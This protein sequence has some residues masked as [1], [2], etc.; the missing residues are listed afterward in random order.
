MV[1][2]GISNLKSVE[3]IK[4]SR[5]TFHPFWRTL[6][7]AW[8]T[9]QRVTRQLWRETMVGQCEELDGPVLVEP[10]EGGGQLGERGLV[11]ARTLVNVPTEV[12][13][14]RVLNANKEERVIRAGTTATT[15]TPIKVEAEL[16]KDEGR[17]SSEGLPSHLLGLYE[18]SKENLGPSD[19]IRLKECLVEFQ[20]VFSKGG[21]D[22]GH[23][24]Q[25]KHGIT[26]GNVRPVRGPGDI[27]CVILKKLIDRWEI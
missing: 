15:V 5:V 25:V 2:W 13:P 12:V 22:I 8:P 24:N 20:D 27:L 9:V 1:P 7:L 17:Q 14:V 11:F 26:T 19:H 16:Y 3:K 6:V 23:T 21:G 10:I 4:T 18:R